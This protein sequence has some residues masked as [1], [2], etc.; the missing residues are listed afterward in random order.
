M[1]LAAIVKSILP[2]LQ[3]PTGLIAEHISHEKAEVEKYVKDPL[4]HGKISV[5]LFSGTFKAAHNILKGDNLVTIPLL[6][7]HGSEDKITSPEG[8]VEFA[9]KSELTTLR[10]WEG[11]YHELHNEPFREELFMEVID[12]L[13]K[14]EM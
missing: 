3:Q 10:L 13:S 14:T 2:G 4:V 7:I 1:I 11:G 12:W 8:S 6:I 9:A 5:A